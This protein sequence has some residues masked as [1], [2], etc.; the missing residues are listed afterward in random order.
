M[1]RYLHWYLN[2][3]LYTL[4]LVQQKVL[5][6]APEIQSLGDIQSS[7]QDVRRSRVDKDVLCDECG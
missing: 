4:Y 6:S 2:H 7:A 5:D 3:S 1:H